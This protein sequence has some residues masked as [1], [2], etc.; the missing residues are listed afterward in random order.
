MHGPTA[1][2]YAVTYKMAVALTGVGGAEDASSA[3]NSGIATG[4]SIIAGGGDYLLFPVAGGQGD[5]DAV[6]FPSSCQQGG[7][8]LYLHVRGKQVST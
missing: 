6:C 7:T 8:Q 4:S 5:R 2:A 3:A 1:R